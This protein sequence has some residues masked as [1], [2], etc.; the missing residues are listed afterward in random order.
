M[1]GIWKTLREKLR[2]PKSSSTGCCGALW[3]SKRF[4]PQTDPARGGNGDEVIEELAATQS[5][6]E[7]NLAAALAEERQM[8]AA[9][10]MSLAPA[11]EMERNSLMNWL[12]EE[13]E[14]EVKREAVGIE[15]NCCVCMEKKKGAAFIPCGHAF[16]RGCAR[17]LWIERRSCPLCN[18]PILE[19]LHIF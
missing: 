9:E 2:F 14:E 1:S 6:G 18:R 12:E 5:T 15:E 3:G 13:E 4:S 11:V 17:D 8:R 16:C 7:M 10:A 19:I